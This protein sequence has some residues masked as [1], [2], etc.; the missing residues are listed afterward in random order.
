MLNCK[1]VGLFRNGRQREYTFL[2]NE[3]YLTEEWIND[4]LYSIKR[5][6]LLNELFFKYDK[7][8]LYVLENDIN[9]LRISINKKSSVNLQI[10]EIKKVLYLAFSMYNK[11]VL[12]NGKESV[13]AKGSG[14]VYSRGGCVSGV[15]GQRGGESE[16]VEGGREE[17]EQF[18]PGPLL[19]NPLC[20]ETGEESDS[21]RLLLPERPVNVTSEKF[22]NSIL[23]FKNLNSNSLAVDVHSLS[24]YDSM[25]CLLYDNGSAGVAV[26]KSGNVVSVFKSNKSKIRGFAT[27]A[28]KDA[29]NNGG[30]KLDCYATRNK[31]P[32]AYMQAG[33][34]PVCKIKF[35]RDFAPAGWNYERDGEPDIVF[36]MIG[37]NVHDRYEEYTDE[38]VPYIEDSGLDCAYE[39]A[40]KYRDSLLTKYLKTRDISKPEPNAFEIVEDLQNRMDSV[41]SGIK[42]LFHKKE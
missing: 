41:I 28:I 21:L 15:C 11:G 35:N 6:V 29:I 37:D 42:G 39:R 4:I 27:V 31:L 2:Y 24:D 26:E 3:K 9:R 16:E 10:S 19:S 12:F 36:M 17:A 7:F 25:S 32:N 38:E 5:K 8:Y 1:F 22:R 30:T 34:R 13:S 40:E 20:R 23:Q 33:M 18:G 14:N